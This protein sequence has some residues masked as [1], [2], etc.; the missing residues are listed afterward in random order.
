MGRAA[1]LFVALGL[2]LAE[3]AEGTAENCT[4]P[5]TLLQL[6]H[7]NQES[8]K[9]TWTDGYA[10]CYGNYQKRLKTND[11]ACG[12]GSFIE[13][14]NF[15]KTTALCGT[16]A[17]EACGSCIRVKCKSGRDV[18]NACKKRAQTVRV[19][20]TLGADCNPGAGKENHV[21]DLNQ[22]PFKAI[23][24]ENGVSQ[25]SGSV[26]VKY[27]ATSCKRL[28]KGGIK[29]GLAPKQVDPYCPPFTFS[30]I[31]AAGALYAVR[32]SSNGGKTWNQYQRNSGNG[33]RWDCTSNQDGQ[34]G[35]GTYLGN[36]ISFDLQLCDIGSLPFECKPSGKTLTI[37]NALPRDWC[38]NGFS[39]CTSNSWQVSENFE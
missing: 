17:H 20:D 36:K 7:A 27:K 22:K 38:A 8:A 21:L 13:G 30:N 26:Y 6:T 5:S 19:I 11:V 24:T 23:S 18:N 34:V 39:P 16:W 2:G 4:E 29:I 33:A 37:I 35:G 32:V 15:V 10:S 9:P 12:I 1:V 31:G 3:S 28:A 14:E 25:C